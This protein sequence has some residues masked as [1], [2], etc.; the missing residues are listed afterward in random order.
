MTKEQVEYM[1]SLLASIAASQQAQ[2]DIMQAALILRQEEG[3]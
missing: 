3:I 1:L 2:A